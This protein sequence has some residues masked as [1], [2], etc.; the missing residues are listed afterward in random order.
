MK[1]I[2]IPPKHKHHCIQAVSPQI[3][4]IAYLNHSTNKRPVP[5]HLKL[6]LEQLE[7]NLHK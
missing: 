6:I 2:T 4:S 1:E 3:L 7:P 5:V